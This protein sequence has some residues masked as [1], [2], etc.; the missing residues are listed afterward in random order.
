LVNHT[1]LV[2]LDSAA[3]TLRPQSV[4][5]AIV[6]FYAKT[7][8]NPSATLHHLARE[9][10]AALEG[11]RAVVAEFVGAQDPLELIFTRGTTE[12]LNLVASTWG[13]SHVASGDEILIGRGEHA[14]NM[15]PWSALSAATGARLTTFDLRDDGSV[16][17]DDFAARVTARTRIV[18]FS[19][20]SNVL[21]IVNP[22][23]EMARIARAENRIVVVDGAQSVP[24]LPVDVTTLGCDFLAFSSHKM[25]GPMGVGALWGR[26]SLLDAM[27][28][29]QLGSNMAHEVELDHAAYS[30]GAHKYGAGTPNVSGPVGFAAAVEF[31]RCAGVGAIRRHEETIAQRM[32][33][34]LSALARVRQLGDAT[35]DHRIGVFSF[36]V[37]GVPAVELAQ[38]LDQHG[39]AIRAGDLAA[40]PLLKRLGTTAAARASC[41]LYTSE[42]DVDTFAEAL[43]RLT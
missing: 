43:E 42:A 5:D 9:A 28:P 38:R 30:A 17:L 3:T 24:H 36:V 37:D 39:I 14:S 20:V 27:D 35:L 4:I 32:S 23:R 15:L 13:R 26:R 18:A 22:V 6:Q 2:Y 29:Y 12:G 10:H 25:L 40:L 41:Y 8:A 11:A 7:N 31:L 1:P 19:H 16:D 33:R 21:G 34:H